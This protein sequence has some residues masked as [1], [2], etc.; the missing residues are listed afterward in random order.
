MKLV[1]GGVLVLIGLVACALLVL[2]LRK[3]APTSDDYERPIPPQLTGTQAGATV[4]DKSSAPTTRLAVARSFTKRAADM[5]E[6]EK[7]NFAMD[8]AEKYKPVTEKWF[9]SYEGRIPFGLEEFTLDKFH[10]CLG[11]YMYTFMIGD[12]TFTIQDSP[13][14]GLKVSYLMTRKG[15]LE[16]NRLPKTGFMPD[17]N[18]PVNR[19]EILRM[20]NA[21]CGIEF[22]PNEVLIKP[23]AAACAL[24]GGAFVDI[25]PTGKDPNNALNYKIS[26]VFDS[27]GKL[28]NYE[29][30]PF[31]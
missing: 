8:F 22:K 25:L 17:L 13:R 3:T 11:D 23:T 16:L 20:V 10:S 28:V 4:P 24:N 30:D 19:D 18:V 26:L 1:R 14:L 12:I 29:R 9:Q 15:A 2:A 21:D 5:T 7:A 6:T 31:F 27:D